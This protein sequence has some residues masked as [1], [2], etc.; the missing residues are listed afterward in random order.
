MNCLYCNAQNPPGAQSCARCGNP[1]PCYAAPEGFI[2]D[3][4]IGRYV[5]K[6]QSGNVV[7][8]VIFDQYSG[9]YTVSEESVLFAPQPMPP[10]P[11]MQPPPLAPMMQAPPPAQKSVGKTPIIVALCAVIVIAL[12]VV[13]WALWQSGVFGASGDDEPASSTVSGGLSE[14]PESWEI[15][16]PEDDSLIWKEPLIEQAVRDYLD[17]PKGAIT[18]EDLTDI[19]IIGIYGN[20]VL[21]NDD[22]T[23][24]DL[25]SEMNQGKI[26]SLEDIRNFPAIRSISIVDN[27]I[28]DLSPLAELDEVTTLVV[29]RGKVQDL[30]PISTMTA[31]Q[32]LSLK[33]NQISDVKLIIKCKELV[34]L[35][36]SDNQFTDASPLAELPK[37]QYLN[38][39]DTPIEDWSVVE[40]IELLEGA[41]EVTSWTMAYTDFLQA[42]KLPFREFEYYSGRTQFMTIPDMEPIAII[43]KVE[44]YQTSVFDDPVMALLVNIPMADNPDVV[45]T[46]PMYL[47]YAYKDG[48]VTADFTE[49]E[50]T[51]LFSTNEVTGDSVLDGEFL[52]GFVLTSQVSGEQAEEEILAALQSVHDWLAEQNP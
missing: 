45:D 28:S 31:L 29:D 18:R 34:T 15:Q 43:L 1:F 11:M 24:E 26:E 8:T 17:N 5:M 23:V 51:A 9:E 50:Y 10:A 32:S 48:E 4:N 19:Q 7:Q 39:Q 2:L 25:T 37:L 6:T 20:E 42:D 49:Q 40:H 3:P 33:G 21:I 13:G 52:D 47:L 27:P 30:R 16:E 44:F 38:L 14:E 36:L 12:A 46:Y 35:D 41:P 22:S